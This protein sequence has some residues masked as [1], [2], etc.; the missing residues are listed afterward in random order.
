MGNNRICKSFFLNQILYS[1]LDWKSIPRL[2][3]QNGFATDP[4]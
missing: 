4:G 2:G 3:A 1:G